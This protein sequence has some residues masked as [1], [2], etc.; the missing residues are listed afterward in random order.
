MSMKNVSLFIS[1]FFYIGNVKV[2]PG[3][4]A[5]FFTILFWWFLMPLSFAPRLFFLVFL[6]IIA[7]LTIEY[8]LKFFDE[9]DPQSIVIDEFIGMSIP[10][11][12]I[13]SNIT[14]AVVAFIIFRFLDIF[15]P[16]IIYYSQRYKRSMGIL[17]DDILSGILTLLILANYL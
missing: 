15:K 3:T 8:S 17:L 1:T 4:I 14:L 16:S 11:L 13:V 12:F 2:A 6:L 10:M 7:I 9:E 5:S